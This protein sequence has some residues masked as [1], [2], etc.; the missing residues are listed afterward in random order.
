MLIKL[1]VEK[2]EKKKNT[3]IFKPAEKLVEKMLDDVYFDTKWL[4]TLLFST[5]LLTLYI[6]DEP[7]GDEVEIHLPTVPFYRS[8]T[9]KTRFEIQTA[10]GR[11]APTSL[12]HPMTF[13]YLYN[14]ALDPAII[15][16]KRSLY[17]GVSA[18]EITDEDPREAA[19]A[20]L[21][22]FLRHHVEFYKGSRLTSEQ[23]AL[24]IEGAAPAHIR[25]ALI[26][27]KT[28][29]LAVR[30]HFNVGMS[31]RSARI[32]GRHQKF[33]EDFIVLLDRDLTMFFDEHDYSETS[34][35]S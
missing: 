34:R 8:T 19:M 16:E 15:A 4:A 23:L 21:R 9:K 31:K 35:E 33:W 14:D 26:D 27:R 3:T 11:W 13:L 30:E 12:T 22:F 28:I 32:D 17:W 20:Y 24:A 29:T 7:L 25:T 10:S 6:S 18:A 5:D 1:V 2:S